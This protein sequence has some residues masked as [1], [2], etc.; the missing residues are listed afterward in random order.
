M[1][2]NLKHSPWNSLLSAFGVPLL[3]LGMLLISLWHP[4]LGVK[5]A[6]QDQSLMYLQQ[7]NSRFDGTMAVYLNEQAKSV[8]F[9]R[10]ERR[11][12]VAHAVGEYNLIAR[13]CTPAVFQM[14]HLPSSLTP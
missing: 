4:N 2:S 6:M 12:R 14:T 1:Q 8:A 7:P 9:C 5:P 10:A 13:E 3:G 11:T